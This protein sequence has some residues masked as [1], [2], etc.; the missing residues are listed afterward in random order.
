MR[1]FLL[2]YLLSCAA[3]YAQ[4]HSGIQ[5]YSAN[6]SYWEYKGN[7]VLLLGASVN[8]NLFQTPHFE[9][10]LDSLYQA[11]GNYIRNTMSDRDPGDLRAFSR[12]SAGKFDLTQWNEAYWEQLDQ[13]LKC[14]SERD[15]IVQIEIWDRFD[16]SR[17][18]WQTDPWNP[19]N[20][21]N[22]SY[23]EVG[24]RPEYARHPSANE[25]PFF[26]S[27]PELENNTLLLS[28]QQAFVRKL[29][30]VSLKYDNILY[31]IDNET[32]GHAEWGAYWA[33]FI[34]Q[35]AKGRDVFITEMWDH[36]DVSS[37]MHRRTI[38]HPEVYDF[39]DLSQNS[40]TPRYATWVNPRAVFDRL[41]E[42]PR[43]VNSVKI[44]GS[45]QSTFKP[46]GIDESH[47][48]QSFFRNLLNGF[49]SARFH[50]PT[51][52]LGLSEPSINA[53]QTVRK[54]ESVVK[55]WDIEPDMELLDDNDENE[56]YVAARRNE[57]YVVYFTGKG[58]VRLN[59]QEQS[60]PFRLQWIS[61]ANSSWLGSSV[62]MGGSWIELQ[63]PSERG[64]VAVLSR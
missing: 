43:P 39:V 34:R 37:D 64:A 25:Q 28:F 24:M 57:A 58:K 23:E 52:G 21:V 15:I 49:A 27:V 46:R 56:A 59:L 41:R 20:N 40:Q 16:H 18:E 1:P 47:A 26:L 19:G 38:D 33:R 12:N 60:G 5:P 9:S 61:V 50:R 30:S 48:I 45:E 54:I 22:Y 63:S 35:E 29:L 4:S 36:W 32:S 7:P 51:S 6:S 2:L 55:F 13:L 53:I 17:R 42:H 31:C 14:A 44:Y 11:G 62:V 8:D 10:H 3:L